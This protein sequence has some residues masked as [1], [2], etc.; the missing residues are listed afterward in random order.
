MLWFADT[1]SLPGDTAIRSNNCN[2]FSPEIYFLERD[3]YSKTPL[4]ILSTFS[5]DVAQ[6]LN[7]IDMILNEDLALMRP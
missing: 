1:E 4:L 2:S 3:F 7:W 5:L 6:C